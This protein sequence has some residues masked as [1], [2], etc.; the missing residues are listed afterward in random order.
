[1]AWMWLG[2]AIALEVVATSSL[3]AADGFTRLWPSLLVV[4][5]YC[6]SVVMLG[7]TLKTFDVGMVYAIWSG[8]GTAVILL[9]GIA[10]FDEPA[11]S[12]RLGGIALIIVG[13][14]MLNLSGGGRESPPCDDQ[15]VAKC[16]SGGSAAA[17]ADGSWTSTEER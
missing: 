5:G 2:C 11:T 10:I 8:A 6:G 13:I 14:V 4:I 12:M 15:V 7:L 9:I 3:K 1:M 16:A 17:A